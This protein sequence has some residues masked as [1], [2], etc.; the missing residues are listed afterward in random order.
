M[1]RNVAYRAKAENMG[2]FRSISGFDPRWTNC[3]EA[4]DVAAAIACR[5]DWLVVVSARWAPKFFADGRASYFPEPASP[6][7][8]TALF[9]RETAGYYHRLLA[10]T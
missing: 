2:S 6:Q 3:R 9:C 5:I 7:S 4:L 8:T 1:P 10:A